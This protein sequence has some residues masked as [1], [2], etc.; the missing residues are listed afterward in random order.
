[1]FKKKIILF[2]I[3]SFFCTSAYSAGTSKKTTEVGKGGREDLSH[4]NVTNSD[5]RKGLN[6]LKQAKKYEKKK[7]V[8]KAVKRFNDAA[9]FFALANEQYPSEPD[10]LNYLGFSLR[11]AGDFAM[12]EIYYEQGLDIDPEH[13]GINEYLGK[14][15]IQTNRI[16][17]A[18][19]RLEVLKNCNCNEFQEL[20]AAIE[21]RSSKY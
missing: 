3:I 12:A 20:R 19:E 10:I 13:K 7:K 8:D 5:Y 4:M 6:A 21:Q 17:K 11:K 15:Y 9:K 18:K 14:L 16:D 2:L 1:M